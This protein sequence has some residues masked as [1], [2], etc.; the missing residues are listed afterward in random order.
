MTQE[1]SDLV[2]SDN[3]NQALVMSFTAFHA[4][5][6]IGLHQSFI[7][8]LESQGSLDRQLEF[9]P[10]DKELLE[11]KAAG[12]GLTRPEIAVLLA[13]SKITI[14]HALLKS[15]LL[16]DAYLRQIAETAFP[17]SARRKY[18]QALSDHTLYRD[19]IATQLS[20]RIVNE[21]GITFV[22]RLQ[23]E[24]GA[25]TEEVVR[26]HAVASTIFGTRQ[27]QKLIESLDFKIALNTQYEMLF[28]IRH[29][30]NLTTL[31]LV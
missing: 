11:R 7:K 13:Y 23:I 20:N 9:L 5:K 14:K 18:N 24:T 21:M 30:V 31:V 6:N 27:L 3:Y 12:L 29:L 22:Y 1:V 16:E 19:I 17:E 28:N 26:A 4:N 8:E 10:D 25:T 15:K 2:L